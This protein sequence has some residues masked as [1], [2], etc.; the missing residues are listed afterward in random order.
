MRRRLAALFRRWAD[1]IDPPVPTIA[2]GLYPMALR[3][4]KE[5]D[6]L[7]RA[8]S[9]RHLV[10]MKQMEQLTGAS[11]LDINEAIERAVRALRQAHANGH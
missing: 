2:D 11:R 10:V 4:V 7:V 1:W 6:P 3:M 9:I 8:G 5:V